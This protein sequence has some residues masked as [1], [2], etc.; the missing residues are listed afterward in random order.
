M[1]ELVHS[2]NTFS[3]L[4]QAITGVAGFYGLTV[5]IHESDHILKQVLS[6]EMI[7]QIIE[8]IFYIGFYFIYNLHTLTESRYYDWFL[9]TP[10]MLFTIALYFFYTNFIEGKEISELTDIYQF[11]QEHILPLSGIILLNFAMLLFGF[12][13]ERGILQRSTSFTLGSLCLIGS[14]GI[15]YKNFAIFSKQTRSI[16]WIMFSLWSMYGIAFLLPSVSKNLSYTVLDIFAKN[17]FGLFLTY[18]IY[19][20]RIVM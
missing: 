20:K 4:V 5:P 14:F 16:F 3:L 7:V 11:A 15:L 10:I 12:L 9:S 19:Q 13:G 1:A 17:F 6:L 8:F 2:A 18:T